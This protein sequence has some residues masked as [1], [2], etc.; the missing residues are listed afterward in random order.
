M[1][2]LIIIAF[3]FAGEVLRRLLPLP[4]PAS[5]YGIILLFTALELKIV[6]VA[7]IRE[8]STTLIAAMPV[9]F[10]P[11]AVG[12]MN[13]WGSIRDSWPQYLI[14]TVISTLAVMAAAGWSTQ[15]VIKLSKSRNK[16]RTTTEKEDGKFGITTNEGKG[17]QK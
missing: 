8:V 6:K 2:L 11:P 1:Q 17:E 4:F 10:V 5:I 3:S 7:N 15:L 14:I 12:L 9:M 16:C 13:T